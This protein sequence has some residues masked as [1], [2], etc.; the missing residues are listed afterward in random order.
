[1]DVSY[2]AQMCKW[3]L[4]YQTYWHVTFFSWEFSL[5]CLGCRHGDKSYIRSL[6]Y[7]LI[8]FSVSRT[9]ISDIINSTKSPFHNR[10]SRVHC[11]SYIGRL[12][13]YNVPCVWVGTGRKGE[14]GGTVSAF[15]EVRY[16]FLIPHPYYSNS[17]EADLEDKVQ[18]ITGIYEARTQEIHTHHSC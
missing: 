13:H 10:N 17:S 3:L 18:K 6:L 8:Y 5:W 15:K 1:M 2:K 7:A 12:G 9:S 16:F 14:V 4:L 11:V